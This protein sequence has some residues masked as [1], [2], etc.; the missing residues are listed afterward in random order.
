[1]SRNVA[2]HSMLGNFYESSLFYAG[3]L[4]LWWR[5]FSTFSNALE[6]MWH[7]KHSLAM[8]SFPQA[9]IALSLPLFMPLNVAGKEFI[10]L[11]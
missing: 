2:E 5:P 8:L 7:S 6:S 9:L 4:S 11:F 3:I 10:D 1:M